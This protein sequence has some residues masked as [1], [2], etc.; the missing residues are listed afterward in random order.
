MGERANET[1]AVITRPVNKA[2]RSIPRRGDVILLF[3]LSRMA[4]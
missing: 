1:E 2:P 4:P 3:A